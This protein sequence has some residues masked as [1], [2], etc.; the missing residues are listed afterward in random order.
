MMSDHSAYT[1]Q[2]YHS[3][4]K[5][6]LLSFIMYMMSDHSAYTQQTYHSEHKKYLTESYHVYDVGSLPTALNK[7]NTLN[8]NNTYSV[9]STQYMM[10]DHFIIHSTNI[11]YYYYCTVLSTALI[12]LGYQ[13]Q[14]IH[15][16][17]SAAGYHV[18][19]LYLEQLGGLCFHETELVAQAR[20]DLWCYKE[21]TGRGRPK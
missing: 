6:N 1:Q 8:T 7:T 9:L 10:S 20:Q 16:C 19:V 11:S 14:L 15:L 18:T 12:S 3:E 17:E 2:T 21:L 13:S 5:L 4:H